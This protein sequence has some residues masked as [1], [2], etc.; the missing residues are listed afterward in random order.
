MYSPWGIHLISKRNQ[1]SFPTRVDRGVP[2]SGGDPSGGRVRKTWQGVPSASRKPSSTN[3]KTPSV[4]L[5][6]VPPKKMSWY[7]HWHSLKTFFL[8]RESGWSNTTLLFQSQW[9]LEQV[10]V[11]LSSCKI[12]SLELSHPKLKPFSHLP[13]ESIHSFKKTVNRAGTTL[14]QKTGQLEKTTDR[15]F[16]DHENKFKTYHP[17]TTKT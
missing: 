3:R 11:S 17:T 1:G 4:P 2:V 6:Q 10:R 14:M 13:L 9:P 12:T 8:F 15:E 7:V 16:Q 5:I